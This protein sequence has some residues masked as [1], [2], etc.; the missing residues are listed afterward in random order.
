ML[1]L[2]MGVL[3]FQ[4]D[5]IEIKFKNQI[6]LMEAYPNEAENI[7]QEWVKE[8]DIYFP[9]LLKEFISPKSSIFIKQKI[10]NAFGKMKKEE[11]LP[12]L[13][14]YL[15]STSSTLRAACAEAIGE[16][17]NSQSS[18]Y[19]IPLLQ[20]QHDAVRGA[21][22]S[23]LGK[24]KDKNAV[25]PLIFYSLNDPSFVNRA[26]AIVSLSEIGD[27]SA[28]SYIIKFKDDENE[29]VRASVAKA[30]SKFKDTQFLLI[31]EELIKDKEPIVRKEA[32]IAMS[33]FQTEIF[34]KNLRK[35]IKDSSYIVRAGIPEIISSKP[36][37]PE[38]SITILYQLLN[39]P[40]KAVK[41]KVILTLN[42][43]KTNGIK[44]FLFIIKGN[45][46]IEQKR[47]AIENLISILGQ[48]ECMNMLLNEFPNWDKKK[49]E[50]I[51]T[52]QIEKGMTK[53]E[54]YLSIGKP[55]RIRKM[56][57]I[58]EWDYDNLNKTLKFKGE[59]FIGE[60]EF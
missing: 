29:I 53:E 28:L 32:L 8:P 31:L 19:L 52:G 30:I 41:E 55:S 60:K 38:T 6:F 15:K 46:P 43:I 27:K 45:Y 44:G 36:I 42:S 58:E 49:T 54:V 56:G 21:A 35:A 1:N 59:V 13:Y 37:P 11:A 17:G 22:I 47:W 33:E 50:K 14:N 57:E 23:S 20:D 7:I 2:L 12:H 10:A 16:I 24:L 51:V 48:K 39:D 9:Y 3:I 5:T 34:Y 40:E 4:I 18:S 25:T 26:R